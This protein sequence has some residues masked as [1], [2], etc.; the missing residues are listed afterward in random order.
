MNRMKRMIAFE[1][2]ERVIDSCETYQHL[3]SAD[4][5][6]DNFKVIYGSDN[7]YSNALDTSYLEKNADM[8]E[9]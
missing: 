2:V 4:R 1:K 3:F 8:T 5:M 9:I 7:I 6:I